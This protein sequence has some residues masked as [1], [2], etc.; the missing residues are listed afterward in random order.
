MYQLVG[1]LSFEV[2]ADIIHHE[3]RDEIIWIV[4]IEHA[5]PNQT[6]FNRTGPSY[7]ET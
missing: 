2:G 1:T 7:M 5:M 6:S 4:R 3:F